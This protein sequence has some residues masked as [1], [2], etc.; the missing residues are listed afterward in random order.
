MRRVVLVLLCVVSTALACDRSN[1]VAPAPV[2]I[3]PSIAVTVPGV[4]IV[5]SITIEKGRSAFATFAIQK[6][7]RSG[8]SAGQSVSFTLSIKTDEGD[9]VKDALVEWGDGETA[10]LGAVNQAVTSHSFSTAGTFVLTVKVDTL[11]G[12]HISVPISLTV[13]G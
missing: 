1:V 11:A 4:T 2:P 13:G 8:V 3:L 7:F 5:A 6:A 9:S 12:G 10:D